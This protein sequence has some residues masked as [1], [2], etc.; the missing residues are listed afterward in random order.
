MPLSVLA[1]NAPL[2]TNFWF[3]VY[4]SHPIVYLLTPCI[5]VIVSIVI[6]VII[7]I[8]IP[9]VICHRRLSPETIR[10]DDTSLLSQ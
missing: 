5:I 2:T 6:L 4:L 1:A 3:F 8:I 9:I 7:S 10:I